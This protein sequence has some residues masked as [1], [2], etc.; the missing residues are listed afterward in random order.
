MS[1]PS[2]TSA[3]WRPS[4][5]HVVIGPGHDPAMDAIRDPESEVVHLVGTLSDGRKLLE[6]IATYDRIV[7]WPWTEEV[8]A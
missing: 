7:Y 3:S 2:E 4:S 5:A 8:G 6:L 1:L